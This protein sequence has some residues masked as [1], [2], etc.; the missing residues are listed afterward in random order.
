MRIQK[1]DFQVKYKK[2]YKLDTKVLILLE[3]IQKNTTPTS[4]L[5][6]QKNF[7][8]VGILFKKSSPS[9]TRQ[10]L[11]CIRTLSRVYFFPTPPNPSP[12]SLPSSILLISI[13]SNESNSAQKSQTVRILL[14]SIP[15]TNESN[16][17]QKSKTVRRDTSTILLAP[18]LPT[19]PLAPLLSFPQAP[20]HRSVHQKSL[21]YQ[22]SSDTA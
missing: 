10:L 14:I 17:A 15:S 9:R 21:F 22:E 13:P 6:Q 19:K 7:P 12:K 1:L 11:K 5:T 20:S 2:R 3:T 18:F 4:T 16:S 8:A